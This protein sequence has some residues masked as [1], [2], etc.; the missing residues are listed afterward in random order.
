MMRWNRGVGTHP[1]TLMPLWLLG[2][3]P[4]PRITSGVNVA[5]REVQEP[6][7]LCVLRSVHPRS[8]TS[9]HQRIPVPPPSPHHVMRHGIRLGAA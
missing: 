9:Q 5:L 4:S 2:D 7:M 6:R 3:V 8:E 1:S